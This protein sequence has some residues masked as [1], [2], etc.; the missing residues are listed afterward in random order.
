[1]LEDSLITDLEKLQVSKTNCDK[2]ECENNSKETFL[3]PLYIVDVEEECQVFISYNAR[4]LSDVR[5]HP[6]SNKCTK[7]QD[8]YVHDH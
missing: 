2:L 1:M 6:Y 8:R 5:Y 3:E 4:G 7:N